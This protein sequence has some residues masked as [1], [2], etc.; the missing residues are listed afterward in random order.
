MVANMEVD[1][2]ADMEV[3]KVVDKVPDMVADMVAEMEVD[4]VA[5]MV[6]DME[7]DTILTNFHHYDNIRLERP[8]GVKDKVKHARSGLKVG[9]QRVPR[10][11]F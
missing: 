8:K 4:K 10:L 7:V 3:D 5:D 9:V 6:A 1:K 11:L 2:V